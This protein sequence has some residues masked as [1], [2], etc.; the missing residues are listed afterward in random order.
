MS[1]QTIHDIFPPED[2]HEPDAHDWWEYDVYRGLIPEDARIDLPI[3]RQRSAEANAK[4]LAKDVLSLAV[5]GGMPDT[6]WHTDPRIRRA[7]DTLGISPQQAQRDY[8]YA[9]RSH[10][11][12]YVGSDDQHFLY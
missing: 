11:D 1:E 12:T 5:A 2:E 4:N 7:C 3:I 9:D 8:L 6:F 10:P